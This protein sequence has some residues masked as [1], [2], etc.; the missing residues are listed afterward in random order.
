[1]GFASWFVEEGGCFPTSDEC[2]LRFVV[3]IQDR[4]WPSSKEFTVNANF[5]N[6]C[7]AFFLG[8]GRF[9]FSTDLD[10]RAFTV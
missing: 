2:I 7:V 4:P 1:M 10:M 3:R 8:G 6:S 9:C 5:Q